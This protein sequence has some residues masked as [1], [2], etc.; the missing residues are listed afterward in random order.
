[1]RGESAH[2]ALKE[3]IVRRLSETAAKA[4]LFKTIAEKEI[5]WRTAHRPGI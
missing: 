5:R 2:E 4:R 1:M 3:G